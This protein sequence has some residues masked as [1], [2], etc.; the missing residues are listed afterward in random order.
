MQ[1]FQLPP[2]YPRIDNNDT[3]IVINKN[4]VEKVMKSLNF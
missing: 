4:D 3:V 2:I 1:F